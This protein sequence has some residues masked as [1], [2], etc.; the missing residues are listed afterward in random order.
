MLFDF[1]AFETE[2]FDGVKIGERSRWSIPAFSA[3]V[4]SSRS[5]GNITEVSIFDSIGKCQSEL[6][7]VVIDMTIGSYGFKVRGRAC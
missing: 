3:K 6:F 4:S 1:K 7:N 2:V 5:K